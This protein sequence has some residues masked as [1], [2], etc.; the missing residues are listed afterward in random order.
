MVTNV[1]GAYSNTLGA[2]LAPV[3]GIYVFSVNLMAQNT[4]TEHYHLS[5]NSKPVCI[6]YARA[7]ESPYATTGQTAI[8]RLAQGDN[9]E[10][11][12]QDSDGSVHGGAYSSFAGFLLQQEYGN[13]AVVGK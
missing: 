1:G 6:M 13:P 2:F 9:V 3:D 7:D 5:K 11:Q 4:Q 8:L 10:I 12:T